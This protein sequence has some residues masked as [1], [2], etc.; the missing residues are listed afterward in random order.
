MQDVSRGKEIKTHT[1]CDVD[2]SGDA[3]DGHNSRNCYKPQFLHSFS[4]HFR[5]L[6]LLQN[7]QQH[8]PRSRI[9]LQTNGSSFKARTS[10]LE[11]QNGDIESRKI[12]TTIIETFFSHILRK[13]GKLVHVAS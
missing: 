9:E 6:L 4:T 13:M 3:S 7:T 11:R 12:T 2:A 10:P 5:L 1:S 8:P